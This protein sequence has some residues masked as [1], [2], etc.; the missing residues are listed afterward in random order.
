MKN[1]QFFEMIKERNST[2]VFDSSSEISSSEITELLD[3]AMSAPSA[4][5]LQHWKFVVFHGEHAQGRLLPVAY[6]QGQIKDAACVIAVLADTQSAKNVDLV[7]GPA[8][9]A[10]YMTQEAK[11]KLKSNVENAYATEQRNREQGILNSS[12]AGMQLIMAASAKGWN[13]CAIGGFNE[14]AFK[15]TFLTDDRY[16]PTMLI[17]IGKEKVPGHQT[18]RFSA[19]EMSIWI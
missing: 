1:E 7:F 2:R 3:A 16:I 9:E 13:T 19:K 18:S 10:G 11:D 6:N 15:E 4:W 12:L 14:Q 8:V 17:A 5:N